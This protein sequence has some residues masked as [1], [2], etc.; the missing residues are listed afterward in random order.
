MRKIL[1]AIVVLSLPL[2]S[3]FATQARLGGLGVANWMV[4]NDDS[5]IWLNPVRISYYPKTLFAELGTAAGSGA[6]PVVDGNLAVATQWGGISANCPLVRGAVLGLFLNRPYWGMLANAGANAAGS[7]VA[8]VPADVFGTAFTALAPQTQWELF[9]ALPKIGPVKL[10]ALLSF[11]GDYV[12][13]D[14]SNVT[15]P[16]PAANDVT[17]ND[18]LSSSDLNLVIGGQ[19]NNLAIISQLDVAISVG[20]PSAKNTYRFSIYNGT[21][22]I[23]VDDWSFKT[24]GATNLGL[25]ARA[26]IPFKGNPL[27]AYLS[28]VSADISNTFDQT[29]DSNAN[30]VLAPADGDTYYQQKRTQKQ[31][32]ITLGA[33]YNVNISPK[34]MMIVAANIN[35]TEATNNATQRELFATQSGIDAE[36]NSKTVAVNIPVNLAIE[37]K[38]S[39]VIT[40]RLGCSQ[41]IYQLTTTEVSDPDY[42]W[43]GSAYVLNNQINNTSKTQTL[44][45]TTI[46]LGAGLKLLDNLMLDAVVRQQVLFSGTYLI[47]GVPETLV[48]QI[49]AIYR[50]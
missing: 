35:Q 46:S 24:D 41:S 30:E 5:L 6:A 22:W 40:G 26:A 16:N 11:A 14:N 47:S 18:E 32:T 17:A 49:S 4:E 43:N 44:G 21:K 42:N 10:G 45:A 12:S 1:L 2:G 19:L 13:N 3:I 25:T 9:Y 48:S 37:H 7:D 20:M 50:F 23:N 28:Y 15:K 39:S 34:T 36:Y 29:I 31:T 27:L 33:S 38:V 8:A